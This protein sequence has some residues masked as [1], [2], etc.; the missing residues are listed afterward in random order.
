MS[1]IYSVT[2]V[3][4]TIVRHCVGLFSFVWIKGEVCNCTFSSSG[5][6]Y[7]SLKENNIVLDCVW[8]ESKHRNTISHDV[9][10]GEVIE[11]PY[12]CLSKRIKNGDYIYV[13]G[14]LVIYKERSKYQIYV[15]LAQYVAE[16]QYSADFY[17]KKQKLMEEGL[18]AYEYKQTIPK[19]PNSIALITSKESAALQ[20]FLHVTLQR[21]LGGH[22]SLYNTT[23]QGKTARQEIIDAVIMAN[24]TDAK[25]IV[26]IRGGGG[27]E[28]LDIFNDELLVRA[29]FGSK[30]PILTGIG[31]E[32]DETLVD[33]VADATGI[34]PTFVAHMLFEDRGVLYR[35]TTNIIRHMYDKVERV[36]Y[37]RSSMLQ[38]RYSLLYIY[39]LQILQCRQNALYRLYRKLMHWIV[40]ILQKKQTVFLTM[41]EYYSKIY[42]LIWNRI[43][44]KKLL[45]NRKLLN[46]NMYVSQRDSCIKYNIYK[47][48]LESYVVFDI[49]EKEVKR[50]EHFLQRMYVALVKC[51]ES[52]TYIFSRYSVIMESLSVERILKNGYVYVEDSNGKRIAQ[53]AVLDSSLLVLHFQDGSVNVCVT[54]KE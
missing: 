41:L 48:K 47:K 23:M 31:H 21:G 51:I 45:Y 52:W 33:L 20:D 3:V 1:R 54:S 19:N 35:K 46:K 44:T 15:D 34:T 2:E 24:R 22:I 18:F 29:I 50:L 27:K 43:D 6:I 17:A 37:T 28:E 38:K 26:I 11:E 14:N 12:T 53:S 10:T 49:L 13:A 8:F 32:I 16:G 36:L 40:A 42:I 9:L 25:A 5:T 4:T 30:I 7:F 39:I